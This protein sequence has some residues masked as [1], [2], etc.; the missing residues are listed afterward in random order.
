MGNVDH[1]VI[2]R[3]PG[4]ADAMAHMVEENIL[5]SSC[6]GIGL[7][8]EEWVT[9]ISEIEEFCLRLDTGVGSVFIMITQ[10]Q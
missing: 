1:A 4:Q 5:T 9:K 3:R 8:A 6:A 10:A 2:I 7:L